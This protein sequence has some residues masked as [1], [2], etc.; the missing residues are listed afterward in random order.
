MVGNHRDGYNN[1]TYCVAIIP[2]NGQ[3]NNVIPPALY[4]FFAR[5]VTFA[6]SLNL[7]RITQERRMRFLR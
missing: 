6:P 7:V 3:S 5:V 1:R 2:V 4:L